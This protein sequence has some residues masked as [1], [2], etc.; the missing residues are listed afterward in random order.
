MASHVSGGVDSASVASMAEKLRRAYPTTTPSIE[1]LTLAFPGL[2]CDEQAFSRTVA[3]R[4]DLRLTAVSALDTDVTSPERSARYPDTYYRPT[5]FAL[6]LLLDVARER[7]IRTTMAGFGADQLMHRAEG[8]ELGDHLRR[9]EL[10]RALRAF[11]PDDR[12]SVGALFRIVASA[13]APRSVRPL[14]RRLRGRK[15]PRWMSAELAR[16]VSA[17][18]D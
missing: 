17:R 4:W 16:D 11:H 10:T 15:L 1:L 18:L 3:S 2:A 8:A 5:L 13:L 14:L 7:G 9:G 12:P 6:G